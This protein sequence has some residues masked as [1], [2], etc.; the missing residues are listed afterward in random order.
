MYNVLVVE[1][2]ENIL[3]LMEYRLQKNGYNVLCARNGKQALDVI[4]NQRVDIMV[5]DIMMPVMDGYELVERIRSQDNQ[6]PVIFTTAKEGISDKTIGFKM[7]IDDYMVKPINHE[8]LVLRIEAVMK[9]SN[10]YQSQKLVIGS[11]T[12]DD[13]NLTIGTDDKQEKLTKKEFELLYLLLSHPNHTFSKSDILDKIWG[14]NSDTYEVT[15]KVHVNR[16]RKKIK[17]YSEISIQTIHGLGYK[18][19]IN[20]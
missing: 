2:E 20:V 11:V 5:A 12:L 1:D 16:V 15:L 19:V 14:Y 3:K 7:G 10:P 8:E 13:N 18:G 6:L 17:K 4:E 9:R